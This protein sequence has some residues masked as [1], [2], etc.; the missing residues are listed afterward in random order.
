MS[1]KNINAWFLCGYQD[2]CQREGEFLKE[3][4]KRERTT[5]CPFHIPVLGF[6]ILI[7]ATGSELFR[8]PGHPL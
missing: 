6:D 7:R 3:E 5:D 1:G 2:S 4:R 8:L